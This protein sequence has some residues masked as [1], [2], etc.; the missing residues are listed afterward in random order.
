MGGGEEKGV[1]RLKSQTEAHTLFLSRVI[2]YSYAFAFDWY[3]N[4]L[5]NAHSKQPAKVLSP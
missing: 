2:H 3:T 5:K 4:N 1:G